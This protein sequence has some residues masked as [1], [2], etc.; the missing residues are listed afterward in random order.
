VGALR[1]DGGKGGSA[2]DAHATRHAGGA[3]LVS[4]GGCGIWLRRRGGVLADIEGLEQ[5]RGELEGM[6]LCRSGSGG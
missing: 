6:G 2:S 3:R 4:S 1:L 5:F